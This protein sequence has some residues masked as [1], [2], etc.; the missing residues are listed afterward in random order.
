MKSTGDDGRSLSTTYRLLFTQSSL[1]TKVIE[2]EQQHPVVQSTWPI[3]PVAT[4]HSRCNFCH[5]TFLDLGK[6]LFD[7]G[8]HSA[9]SGDPAKPHRSHCHR[10]GDPGPAFNSHPSPLSRRDAPI[11]CLWSSLPGSCSTFAGGIALRKHHRHPHTHR[12]LFG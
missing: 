6:F 2:T 9:I 12:L 8:L 3:D 11:F 4:S 7:I 1:P 10:Q 5:P